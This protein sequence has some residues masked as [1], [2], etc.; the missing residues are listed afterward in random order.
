MEVLLGIHGVWD[1]F[2]PG[3]GDSKKNNIV[4]GLLFQSILE[5]LILQIENLRIAKVMW[6]AIKTRN[7]GADLVKEAR[8]QT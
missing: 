7:L 4:K 5:D 6:D 1:V 2:D 3:S 8:L